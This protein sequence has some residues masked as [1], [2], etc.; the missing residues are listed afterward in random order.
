MT[1]SQSS[2]KFGTDGWRA[3]MAEDFTFSNVQAVAQA[4]ADYFLRRKTRITRKLMVVGYDRRFLSDEF[5]MT[6]AE[7]LAGNG[8]EVILANTPTPT[9]V[10]K[11]N[12]RTSARRRVPPSAC[13]SA[14]SA[15][16]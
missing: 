8:Y 16:T 9:P 15:A 4:T 1:I 13:S 5:A 3:V 2:I 12:P 7:V 11:V 10:K 6:V 14:A